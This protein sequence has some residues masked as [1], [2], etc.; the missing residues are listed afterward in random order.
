VMRTAGESRFDS[1]FV[2]RVGEFIN[3]F[4]SDPDVSPSTPLF[5]P[6]ILLVK[7]EERGSSPSFGSGGYNVGEFG[8]LFSHLYQAIDFS[9]RNLEPAF[10][11]LW[12]G[13]SGAFEN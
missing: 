13:Q 6:S 4:I 7:A 8:S 3:W 9:H 1:G 5:Q 11:L 12:T 10:L 2:P